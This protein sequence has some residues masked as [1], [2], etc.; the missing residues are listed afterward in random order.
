MLARTGLLRGSADIVGS[1]STHHKSYTKPPE[2]PSTD[3][4]RARSVQHLDA[5]AM[6]EGASN[7]G[8]QLCLQVG[9][10]HFSKGFPM[11]LVCAPDLEPNI[12]QLYTMYRIRAHR[13]DV[14]LTVYGKL[15][16]ALPISKLSHNIRALLQAASSMWQL[17]LFPGESTQVV[18]TFLDQGSESTPHSANMYR[19]LSRTEKGPLLLTVEILND[20]R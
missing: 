13:T 15:L 5:G 11:G 4:S 12:Y 7:W 9:V 19:S 3:G 2:H 8:L 6:A 18:G 10:A 20:L 1:S 16:F 17:R 14:P